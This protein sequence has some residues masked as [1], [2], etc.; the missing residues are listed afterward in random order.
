MAYEVKKVLGNNVVLATDQNE[1]VVVM[2][3]GIGYHAQKYA[4]IDP[5]LIEKIFRSFKEENF[6]KFEALIK[7]IPEEIIKISEDIISFIE[8]KIEEPLDERVHLAI[9]DHIHFLVLRKQQGIDLVNPFMKEIKVLY[10]EEYRIGR[11]AVNRLR[12]KLNIA[13]S[14]DE[15]GFLTLHIYSAKHSCHV[16]EAIQQ[17]KEK[18]N[19]KM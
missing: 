15:I 2:G 14:D 6:L 4:A 1:D 7:Y 3:K 11:E 19:L 17:T 12:K 8:T 9:L 16:K 10:P 18:Y 13:I 5:S